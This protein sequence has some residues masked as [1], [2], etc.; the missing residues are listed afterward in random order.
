MLVLVVHPYPPLVAVVTRLL[1][2]GERGLGAK[3]WSDGP[4]GGGEVRAIGSKHWTGID[5]CFIG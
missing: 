3:M 2:G 1:L 4:E 5:L